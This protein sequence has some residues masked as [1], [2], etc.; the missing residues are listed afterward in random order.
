[1][2]LFKQKQYSSTELSYETKSQRAFRD[3]SEN[4]SFFRD[5]LIQEFNIIESLD[6]VSSTSLNGSRYTTRDFQD[7]EIRQKLLIESPSSEI[8][9]KTN[10][11]GKV[12]RRLIRTKNQQVIP[13]GAWA[14]WLTSLDIYQNLILV[15]VFVYSINIGFMAEYFQQQEQYYYSLGIIPLINTAI[16]CTLAMDILLYWIDDFSGY[17]NN[18]WRIFDFIITVGVFGPNIYNL[19]FGYS[20]AASKYTCVVQVLVVPKI[21]VRMESLRT[22]VVTIFQ[23]LQ[24]MNFIILFII[25]AAT[26]YANLGVNLYEDYVHSTNIGLVYQDYFASI[27]ESFQSI[28]IVMTFDQWDPLDRNLSQVTNPGLSHFFILSWSWLGAFVFRNIF[29]GVMIHNFKRIAAK[30]DEERQAEMEAKKLERMKLKLKRQLEQESLKE[31]PNPLLS[32]DQRNEELEQIHK[33]MEDKMNVDSKSRLT[34]AW[35]KMVEETLEA[36]QADRDLEAFW[37][38]DVMFKYLQELES[39]MENIQEFRELNLMARR[40]LLELHDD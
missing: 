40:T 13:I 5:K 29:V 30:L 11:K 35:D 2:S 12:D 1:M 19:M 9:R 4:A 23:A 7:P 17:W 28:F 15:L 10:E 25:L 38:R 27:G 22:I 32:S 20:T 16:L 14:R 34:A 21:I 36:L 6:I 24:S 33:R 3:L 18:R 31:E 8:R 39:L 26:M 37:P